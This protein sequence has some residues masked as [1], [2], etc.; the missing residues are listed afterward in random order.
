MV[1]L[2]GV[3]ESF[4]A[5]LTTA[6]QL[7]TELP[8]SA[9]SALIP[10]VLFWCVNRRA[11]LFLLAVAGFGRLLNTVVKDTLCVYRPWILD[12][13]VHPAASA[14][15]K[16][17]SYS[18]PSGHTQMATAIYGGLAY[19]YR[20]R[21]PWLIIPCALI[22]LAVGFSRNFLGVHTPQDVL[23]AM[24]ETAAVIFLMGKLFEAVERDRRLGAAAFVAAVLASVAAAAYVLLKEYPVDYLY[25]KVIVT[26]AAARLDSL[27]SIGAA[28]GF[29]AGLA[30]E[31]RFVRFSV[32]VPRAVKIRRVVIGCAVGAAAM[33]VLVLLKKLVGGAAY[34]FCKGFV[35]FFVIIFL[36]PLAFDF[37]ERRRKFAR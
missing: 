3:R 36:A 37:A 19:L 20:R 22:I 10:G 27:D 35:P 15:A 24:L 12:S 14:L 2:Q 11:G 9:V 17:S 13:A 21:A 4:G 23:V 8:S 30:A 18:M 25:G 1:I 28:F 33:V 29:L 34:E 5:W 26:A 32:S 31:F 6:V 7:L 16:A